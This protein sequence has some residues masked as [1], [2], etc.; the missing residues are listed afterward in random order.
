[1][2]W[3][4]PDALIDRRPGP[5]GPGLRMSSGGPVWVSWPGSVQWHPG[6]ENGIHEVH[7]DVGR[8]HGGRC[9]Q[10]DADDHRLV[11][12]VECVNPRLAEA[13]AAE[14]RFGHHCTATWTP[15]GR[16]LI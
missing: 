2:S 10:H 4:S 12:L 8:D 15:K 9:Q 16:C 13:G 6:V 1:M 7:G 5:R 3:T 11:L 14:D